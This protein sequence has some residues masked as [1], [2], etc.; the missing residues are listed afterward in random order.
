MSWKKPLIILSLCV[1]VVFVAIVGIK[2]LNVVDTDKLLYCPDEMV[3]N[4]NSFTYTIGKADCQDVFGLVMNAFDFDEQKLQF[5]TL[6]DE[7]IQSYS[8]SGGMSFDLYFC[9]QQRFCRDIENARFVLTENFTFDSI[10]ITLRP[11]SHEA[12]V[13]IQYYLNGKCCTFADT[14]NALRIKCDIDDLTL[15]KMLANKIIGLVPHQSDGA[16]PFISNVF[17]ANPDTILLY[18]DGQS[19]ELIDEE[20]EAVYAVIADAFAG[21]KVYNTQDFMRYAALGKI[22]GRVMLELRYDRRQQFVA[23][24]VSGADGLAQAYSGTVYQSLLLSWGLEEQHLYKLPCNTDFH[25]AINENGSYDWY[26]NYYMHH[27]SCP[28]LAALYAYMRL[29]V[30]L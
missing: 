30:C 6:S 8:N 1:A 16:E 7:K 28:Q 13:L 25:M 14:Y 21:T 5:C 17:P 12:L 22:Q 4:V 29:R 15:S 26:K 3:C 23:D 11:D 19:V 18:V 2:H 20:K 24:N 10:K 9:K 27:T